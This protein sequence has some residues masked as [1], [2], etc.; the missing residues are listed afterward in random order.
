MNPFFQ[1]F[2][3]ALILVF[4]GAAILAAASGVIIALAFTWAWAHALLP[5]WGQYVLNIT[6][7]GTI[8]ALV[9]AAVSDD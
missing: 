6:V 1:K 8:L 5:T 7:G 9:L 2:I 3:G 4:G